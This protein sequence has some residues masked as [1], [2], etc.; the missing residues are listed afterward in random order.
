MYLNRVKCG[1]VNHFEPTQKSV[2]WW[3]LWTQWWSSRFH[4][5]WEFFSQKKQLKEN[6]V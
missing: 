6:C 5:S 2:Q 1:D 4:K 3:N